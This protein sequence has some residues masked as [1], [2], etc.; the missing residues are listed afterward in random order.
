MLKNLNLYIISLR[1]LK[2]IQI[3]N[4]LYRKVKIVNKNPPK[5]LF[6]RDANQ[7]LFCEEISTVK[8]N[9]DSSINILEKPFYRDDWLRQTGDKLWLYNIHYFD[10]LTID[11]NKL[12][13]QSKL[14]DINRWISQNKN[15][16]EIGWEPYPMS[17]RLVNWIKFFSKECIIEENQID[18]ILLQAHL[19][20]QRLEW[21]ILGNHLF[22]NAKA[23]LFV[24]L[25]FGGKFADQWIEKSSSIIKKQIKEQVLSDGGHFELSPMYHGIFL[26]DILDIIWFCRSYKHSVNELLVNELVEVA[27]KMGNWLSVMTP[28]DGEFAFFNDSTNQIAPEPKKITEYANSLKIYPKL[29]DKKVI[30]TFLSK[31][32][33]IRLNLQSLT[34]LLD[35]GE[36]GPRYLTGH[37]H[38][39]GLC[40]EAYSF[41]DRFLVNSGIST[42]EIGPQRLYERGTNAHNTV[43]VE[44]QNSSEVWSSFRVGRR[45]SPVNIHLNDVEKIITAAHDGYTRFANLGNHNRRWKYSKNSIE[46]YDQLEGK[47]VDAFAYFHFSP[48]C[49]ISINK[50]SINCI[51]N[52]RVINIVV[53]KGKPV[54]Q[55]SFYYPRFNCFESNK[56]LK[57]KL[58]ENISQVKF[59]W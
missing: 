50:N 44:G 28:P 8:I 10:W 31:S 4:R 39:D 51:L 3:L 1:Y 34:F 17:L 53:K 55:K 45:A 48:K 19:L 11:N 21:H 47:N 30:N 52:G 2:T 42:Y 7:L 38:A 25:F 56:T 27:L 37:S 9:E 22:S 33:Y 36:I 40:F 18:S 32:G 14:N 16:N 29:H 58:D 5:F 12:D 13:T 49:K 26:T 35:V 24:G 41:S 59:S 15:I 6:I 43:E 20:S 57:I 54:I 23:M 46:I